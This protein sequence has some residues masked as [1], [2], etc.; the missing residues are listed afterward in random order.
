MC[1][2]GEGRAD[3]DGRHH[4]V[5]GDLVA[6]PAAQPGAQP[7]AQP[8]AQPAAQPAAMLLRYE[9]CR[10][11]GFAVVFAGCFPLLFGWFSLSH[12]FTYKSRVR[13]FFRRLRSFRRP[14]SFL[15]SLSIACAGKKYKFATT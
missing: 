14:Q 5:F 3:L 10:F 8:G 1:E 2:E 12:V 9:V 6:Q 11:L 4:E 7:A 13:V 15:R